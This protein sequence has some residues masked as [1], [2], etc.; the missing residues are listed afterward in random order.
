VELKDL[1]FSKRIFFSLIFILI[2]YN[3][4]LQGLFLY[5]QNGNSLRTTEIVKN[6]MRENALADPFELTRSLVDLEKLGII[7]CVRMVTKN[8]GVYFD[9]SKNPSCKVARWSLQG[10]SNIIET[11][12]I[13]GKSWTIAFR[14]P[15]DRF[16]R[17]SLWVLRLLGSGA[18]VISFLL[19][20]YRRSVI[21]EKLRL[22]EAERDWLWNQTR[23]VKHDVASPITA[24]KTAIEFP[25]LNENFKNFLKNALSRTEEIFND[26]SQLPENSQMVLERIAPS[27]IVNEIVLEKKYRN[28]LVGKFSSEV[29]LDKKEFK[30]AVSNVLDNA[31][32]V[33]HGEMITVVFRSSSTTLTIDFQ[34]SGPGFPEELLETGPGKGKSLGKP[35]GS[36]LGLW[37]AKNLLE[38]LGGRLIIENWSN[39]ARVKFELPIAS[40]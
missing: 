20:T 5:L 1:R 4:F 40:N 21:E 30:R 10:S 22:K 15:N 28:I 9:R 13:N 25:G 27:D 12:S 3:I 38:S 29:T 26:L 11:E 32:Y 17:L 31:I 6:A 16:F 36:G 34:D 23:Q 24:L 35:E 39:G 2:L 37:H 33:S 18:L 14:S 7:D 19:V 8:S